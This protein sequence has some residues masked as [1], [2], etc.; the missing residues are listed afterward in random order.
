MN[1][2]IRGK[3]WSLFAL[4]FLF[5]PAFVRA[6]AISGDLTGAV[7][8]ASGAAI[9]NADVT[10]VNDATGVKASVQTG[11]S[12][13]YRFSNLPVGRYTVS[14]LASGFA[15]DTLKNIDVTLSNVVTANLT[16]AVGSTATTVEVNSG[17]VAIDTTTA[18]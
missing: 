14:A 15:A 2:F 11:D 13:N 18:Q 7:L 5:Q 3:W 16:L 6:Q 8:D 10:A 4:C 1:Q 17:A 9:P 12:G